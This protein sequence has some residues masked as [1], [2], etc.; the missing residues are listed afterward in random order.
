MN[1]PRLV[2]DP[3]TVAAADL[4]PAVDWL[5][6]GGIVAFPTDTF[7]GLAVD[8]RSQAAVRALFDLKGRTARAALP[9]IAASVR[10]VEAACGS[11]GDTAATL[12]ARWWPGPLSLVLDAPADVTAAVHG[13]SR[14]VA[15]RV[16]AHRL[17][18]A[19]VEAWG[20][21]LTATSANLSGEAPAVA[22]GDLGRIARDPRVFVVDGGATAGGAPSTIVDVRA[23][24]VALVRD[25]A[26]PW[27]RVLES[28][29]G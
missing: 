10:Q 29:E 2:V 15:V 13:G 3:A 8:P 23:A 22:A 27:N 4:A 11:L 5:R 9:L 28:L 6:Q 17:A 12:A 19:L 25:G 1:G 24:R 14:S 18:R 26:I 7:Y 20:G 16:P 21:L